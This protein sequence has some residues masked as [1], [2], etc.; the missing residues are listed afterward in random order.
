M[1]AGFWSTISALV[2]LVSAAADQT[3]K[4]KNIPLY[5]AKTRNDG[6]DRGAALEAM[7]LSGNA[8]RG[9]LISGALGIHIK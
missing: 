4:L 1:L 3:G 8:P 7:I 2:E 5:I 6:A 9:M